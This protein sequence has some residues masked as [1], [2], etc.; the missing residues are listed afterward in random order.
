MPPPAAPRPARIAAIRPGFARRRLNSRST[1]GQTW[2]SI[3]SCAASGVASSSAGRDRGGEGDL[4]LHRLREPAPG[5]QLVRAGDR[6]RDDRRARPRS[7]A[8]RRRGAA[9]SASSGSRWR[10]PSGNIASTRPSSRCSRA[11][12]SASGSAVPRR[13][14]NAPS[15]RQQPRRL[16]ALEELGLG[17]EVQVA[18]GREPDEER[19]VEALVVGRDDHGPLGRDVLAAGDLEAVPHGGDR[20]EHETRESRT[21][22]RCRACARGRAPLRSSRPF[23]A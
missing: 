6:A 14:G 15:P 9:P 18:L 13:T 1:S 23:G 19:V 7:R 5:E 20:G 4:D 21:P 12:S 22:T 8:G 2:F 16:L 17:H 3:R 10:V 11:V